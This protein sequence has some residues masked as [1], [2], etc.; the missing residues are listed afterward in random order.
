MLPLATCLLALGEAHALVL[1]T[2]PDGGVY[3][4]DAPP[5]DCRPRD[6]GDESTLGK[7]PPNSHEAGVGLWECDRGFVVATSASGNRCV[8]ESDVPKG[9]TMEIAPPSAW[10]VSCGTKKKPA[11]GDRETA[12]KR[13]AEQF[14]DDFRAQ[15]ACVRESEGGDDAGDGPMRR[16]ERK[17]AA[18]FPDDPRLQARCR[19][20][21]MDALR[22]LG[23]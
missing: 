11:A 14:P 3:A 20:E 2:T 19:L 22:E 12:R 23:R 1:C 13:C 6:P 15:L 17:C 21:Q 10:C 16:I 9:P 18:E 7:R 8:A 5:R 4:G